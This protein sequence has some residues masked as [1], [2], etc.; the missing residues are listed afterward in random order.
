MNLSSELLLILLCGLIILSYL[1]SVVS[2]FIR[3]PSVLLLLFAGIGF[4]ALAQAYDFDIHIPTEIVDGLGVVGLIMIVL[5]AGLDLE[6]SKNK[7][8]L[9]RDSCLYQS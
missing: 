1:F 8:S 6:L 4:R 3:V 9:I 2:Q 7:T 5:E